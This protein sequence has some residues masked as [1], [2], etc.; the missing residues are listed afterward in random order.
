MGR[1]LRF[2]IPSAVGFFVFFWPVSYAGRRSIPLDAATHALGDVLGAHAVP[3]VCTVCMLSALATVTWSWHYGGSA[4]IAPAG[5]SLPA[6]LAAIFVAPPAWAAIRVVGGIGAACYLWQAGPGWLI[7]DS[8]AGSA[9]RDVGVPVT[10]IY[11]VSAVFLPFITDYGLMEFFGVLTRPFFQRAFRLPGRASL[12]ALASW[13]SSGPV[14][15]LIT[16]RQ[17]ESGYY[18]VREA[19]FISTNF[20]IVSVPFSLLVAEVSGIGAYYLPWYGSLVVVGIVTALLT[21]RLPPWTRLPDTYFGGSELSDAARTDRSRQAES[22]AGSIWA[23]ALHAAVEAAQRGLRPGALALDMLR[24]MAGTVLGLIGACVGTVLLANALLEHTLVFQWLSL[25]L[26]PAIRAM[27]LE[28]AAAPGFIIG[29]LDQFLVAV[30][31]SR[32]TDLHTKFVLASLSVAQIIYLSNVGIM[33]MRSS[34]RVR[35]RDLVGIF[36]VRTVIC[37]PLFL[38][39]ARIVIG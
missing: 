29:F 9:I 25:P 27:G 33:L 22:H 5:R 26:V 6:L 12:D 10:R 34:L 1:W 20:H 16:L 8:V 31:A 14:A 15:I 17:F 36:V 19:V 37:T 21:R 35:L 3:L 2:A 32:L 39:A 13:V 23:R 38:V 18:T 30:V 4:R 24:N 28:A 7:A 11:I